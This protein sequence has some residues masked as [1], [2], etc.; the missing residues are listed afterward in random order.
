MDCP[1]WAIR[2]WP[3]GEGL[4]AF[5]RVDFG[6]LPR[7]VHPDGPRRAL[8]SKS[9]ARAPVACPRRKPGKVVGEP[10][11]LKRDEHGRVVVRVAVAF[12]R[13]SVEAVRALN[14]GWAS[15]DAPFARLAQSYLCRTNASFDVS[16]IEVHLVLAGVDTTS[17]DESIPGQPNA[18]ASEIGQ[19]LLDPTRPE[20]AGVIDWWSS[21]GAQSLVLVG[22][23]GGLGNPDNYGGSTYTGWTPVTSDRLASLFDD[24]PDRPGMR[25]FSVVNRACADN[26]HSFAHEIGHQLALQ[27][28]RGSATGGAVQILDL[29]SL[30]LLDHGYGHLH[31]DPRAFTL[32]AIGEGG[33]DRRCRAPVF[34]T[35]RALDGPSPNASIPAWGTA[36]A[37][38]VAL[39]NRL[40]P[41]FACRRPPGPIE[42]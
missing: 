9:G 29:A 8:P 14:A 35:T 30:Q 40:A 1:G 25:G 32:M 12:T 18:P 16:G 11:D 10:E 38:N 13:Q 21:T 15:G 23:L 34:S 4:H 33:E 19:M 3:V 2:L 5:Y 6:G 20:L 27:H 37:D 41:Y 26:E 22:E 28:E 42:P 36:D 24:P 39:A 31:P 17:V 7:R